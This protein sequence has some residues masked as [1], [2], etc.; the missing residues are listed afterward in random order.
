MPRCRDSGYG[1]CEI[2]KFKHC[3]PCLR[4]SY[5]CNIA[6]K[7]PVLIEQ[8][9]VIRGLEKGEVEM[10]LRCAI[11][12]DRGTFLLSPQQIPEPSGAVMLVSCVHVQGKVQ[13]WT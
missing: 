13:L 1:V 3:S 4:S 10:Q 11:L 12:Q 2:K 8:G 5:V 7:N 9:S 6:E